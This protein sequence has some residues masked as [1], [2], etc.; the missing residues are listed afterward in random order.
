MSRARDAVP[1]SS[2][3]ARRW[4]GAAILPMAV[5]VARTRRCR[6]PEGWLGRRGFAAGRPRRCPA[7]RRA[8]AA[9]AG[10]VAGLGTGAAASRRGLATP[11]GTRP[12]CVR[13]A[14]SSSSRDPER[15]SNPWMEAKPSA[16]ATVSDDRTSH[17]GTGCGPIGVAARGRARHRGRVGRGAPTS[18]TQVVGSRAAAGGSIAETA[19][20]RD[21]R[22]SGPIGPSA[23]GLAQE[24][25]PGTKGAS[26]PQTSDTRSSR[27]QAVR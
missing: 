5:S 6:R 17:D 11:G 19:G 7:P 9:S 23:G 22:A 4:D 10:P 25:V 8:S 1:S 16:R 21:P 18:P 26:S 12:A 24:E 13:A 2:P 14:A 20:R 15:C 3:A 27:P